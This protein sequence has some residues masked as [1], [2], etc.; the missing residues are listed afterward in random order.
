MGE[1]VGASEFCKISCDLSLFR[2]CV[3]V[4]VLSV[5]AD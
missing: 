4:E 3:C 2:K 1:C 5:T